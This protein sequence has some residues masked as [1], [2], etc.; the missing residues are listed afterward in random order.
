MDIGEER[1][2]QKKIQVQS[3]RR[4]SMSDDGVPPTEKR[5]LW[6][7]G[8]ENKKKEDQTDKETQNMNILAFS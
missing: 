7:N 5:L 1:P 2:S 8:G 6:L 4:G 3:P